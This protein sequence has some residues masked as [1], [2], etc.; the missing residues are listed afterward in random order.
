MI[1]FIIKLFLVS[2]GTIYL[3]DNTIEDNTFLKDRIVHPVRKSFD[4]YF[5]KIG[6][7]I[8]SLGKDI[9]KI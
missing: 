4:N 2:T 3:A 1:S 5:H 9:E 8:A 7:K 6:E